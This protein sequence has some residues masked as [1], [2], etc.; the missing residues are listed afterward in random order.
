MKKLLSILITLALLLTAFQVVLADVPAPG[1]PFNTW[2]QVQNI[3][4]V[5]ASCTYQFYSP[6]GALAYSSPSVNVDADDTLYV[7]VPDSGIATG[8]YSGVVSCTQPVAASVSFGDSDS[9]AAHSGVSSPSDEWYAPGIYD[10]YWGFYSNIVVQNAHA[11]SNNVTLSIYK[12]NDLIPVYTDTVAVVQNGSTTWDQTGMT[13]LLDNVDYSAKIT[14]DGNVA[15]IVNI[16]GGTGGN[17]VHLYSY[18]PFT[19]GTLKAYAPIIM[20]E[21]FTWRT[22]IVVQNISSSSNNV[23][24]TYNNGFIQTKT[25][26]PYSSWTEFTPNYDTELPPGDNVNPDPIYSAVIESTNSQPL[27]VIVNQSNPNKRAGTYTA[28]PGGAA[29]VYAPILIQSDTVQTY[30]T[31][32]TC[33]N[34]GT[35]TI[36]ITAEF[37]DHP[38]V[39]WTQSGIAPLDNYVFYLPNFSGVGQVPAPWMGSGWF[40]SSNPAHPIACTVNF[41]TSGATVDRFN[42]YNAFQ[43]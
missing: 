5:D 25:M 30:V 22:A 21:Y 19:A 33:E 4:G 37:S 41:N 29:K 26:T 31:S 28:F 13:E 18:N 12:P 15:P 1:G 34:L 20:N 42:T 36:D 8:Q 39:T 6:A 38:G 43:P 7:Y 2:F 14:A 24:I 3:S 23:K 17:A 35:A 16:H 9:E 40:T 11:G 27:V 32:V 10:N